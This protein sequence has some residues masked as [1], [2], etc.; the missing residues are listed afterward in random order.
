MRHYEFTVILSGDG[1]TPEEAW[2][3]AT[4]SFGLEPGICPD[5]TEYTVTDEE[6]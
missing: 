2:N 1:E 3:D 4:E 6:C 5:D